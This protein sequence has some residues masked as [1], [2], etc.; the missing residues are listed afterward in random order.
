MARPS[1][2]VC[3]LA[4]LA[5]CQARSAQQQPAS[6]AAR[7]TSLLDAMGV[8]LPKGEALA[9]MVAEAARHPL[10]SQQNPVRTAGVEGQ[11]RYLSRLRCADGRPPKFKRTF[12]AG[13]GPFG[14]IIDGYDVRCGAERRELF[15]D[16]YHDHVESAPVPGYTIPP[17]AR[18]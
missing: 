6:P 15:L 14:R 2:A 4:A 18:R 10:G 7:S 3:C 13:I 12:S 5:G 17:A 16:M 9:K 8:K 11:H 1:L